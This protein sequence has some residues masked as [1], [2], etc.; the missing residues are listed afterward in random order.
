[1]TG[2]I[3]RNAQLEMS[4][5]PLIPEGVESAW[6]TLLTNRILVVAAVL[7]VLLNLPNFFRIFPSLLDCLSR[8]RGNSSLEHSANTARMRNVTAMAGILPFCLI[9]DKYGLLHPSFFDKVNPL[10]HVFMVIG[11]LLSFLIIRRILFA[12][13]KPHRMHAEIEDTMHHVLFTFF[14]LAVTLMI[15]TVLVTAV[16][17]V[18]QDTV[19]DILMW[20]I[21]VVY[22]IS[23][24]RTAQIFGK[25]VHGFSTILYLCTLEFLPAAAL[26]VCAM[27]L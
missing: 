16:F 27:I 17:K 19:K 23:T 3:F 14:C 21:I 25:H 2:D 20:E 12:L 15:V 5:V 4:S 6:G 10:W 24:L 8:S 9:V 7:I 13:F 1:M 11:F 22:A 26:V 18:P